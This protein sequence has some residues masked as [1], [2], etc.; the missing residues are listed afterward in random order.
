MFWFI[1]DPRFRRRPLPNGQGAAST[2]YLLKSWISNKQSFRTCIRHYFPRRQGGSRRTVLAHITGISPL[3]GSLR[4]A[5]IAC[6]R[7][8]PGLW[9]DRSIIIRLLTRVGLG[10]PATMRSSPPQAVFGTDGHRSAPSLAVFDASSR[11]AQVV[12]AHPPA[13]LQ[14]SSRRASRQRTYP[15]AGYEIFELHRRHRIAP[16][17]CRQREG[18]FYAS[19]LKNF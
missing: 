3:R 5:P 2:S 15:A 4:A 6:S 18:N 10:K 17:L 9:L 7:Y 12:L 11:P 8:H 14:P 16:S 19:F 1:A 13:S